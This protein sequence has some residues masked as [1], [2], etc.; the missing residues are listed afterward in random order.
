VTRIV[1]GRIVG[2]FG[3][4]GWLKLASYTDPPGQILEFPRWQAQGPSGA[5]RELRLAESRPHGKVY[6]VRLEGIDDRDAAIALGKPELWV[7]RAE[8]PVLPAGEHYREDL[9]GYEVVNLAGEALGRVDGFLDLPNSVSHE[10]AE[11]SR[12]QVVVFA[13]SN[14]RK[15]DGF[16]HD[17]LFAKEVL[18]TGCRERLAVDDRRKGTDARPVMGFFHEAVLHGVCQRI[19]HLFDDIIRI[20]QADDAGL[21]GG[22][23]V[24]PSAAERVL[25][26]GEELVEVLEKG[27]VVTVRIVDA[28]VV[29]VAHRD[30]EK[31]LN[32]VACGRFRQ[33]IDE[34]VVCLL[35]GPHQ[36]LPLRAPAG[37]HVRLAR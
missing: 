34:G 12:A 3:V 16:R 27:R 23:E 37:D 30:R 33:T 15:L 31:D 28:R 19:R 2:P 35:V 36:E 32:A 13:R 1:L 22:P 24:L 5:N 25:A 17:A 29:M 4:R 18:R 6:V 14:E 20:D 11:F 26:L 10:R 7:E 21:F 8:L 9:V